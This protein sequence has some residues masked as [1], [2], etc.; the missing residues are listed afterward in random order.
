MVEGLKFLFLWWPGASGLL[1]TVHIYSHFPSSP[2]PGTNSFHTL[3]LFD[4]L[5]LAAAGKTFCLKALKGL[6]QAHLHNLSVLNSMVPKRYKAHN[7]ETDIKHSEVLEIK[8][9]HL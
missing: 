9:G 3:Q 7:H 2:A 5:L 1:K 8:A 6:G 4:F